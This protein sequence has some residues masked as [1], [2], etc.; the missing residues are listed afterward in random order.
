[1]RNHLSVLID[2]VEQWCSQMQAP[3]HAVN[4]Q[5]NS[6][7][8]GAAVHLLEQLQREISRRSLEMIFDPTSD[9]IAVTPPNSKVKTRSISR[10]KFAEGGGSDTEVKLSTSGNK[11]PE[12]IRRASSQQQISR[13]A[14]PARI[15][16]Q[17]ALAAR[18]ARDADSDESPQDTK[19]KYSARI[20]SVQRSK[21]SESEE[22]AVPDVEKVEKQLRELLG[23][24]VRLRPLERTASNRH[25]EP[26]SILNA[27]DDLD[28]G[29][30][31][32]S[33]RRESVEDAAKFLPQGLGQSTWKKETIGQVL[34]TQLKA[35]QRQQNTT[36]TETK[37]T[38]SSSDPPAASS[39]TLLTPRSLKSAAEE[40]DRARVRKRK[41]S[42]SP[43]G[44]SAQRSGSSGDEPVPSNLPTASAS[45]VT[46][47]LAAKILAR[48]LTGHFG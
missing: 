14:R 22:K 13:G 39:P 24:A 19:P 48:K 31:G 33:D 28:E 30:Q 12:T 25:T 10:E 16:N 7:E 34:R 18:R 42:P 40:A 37:T 36:N 27:I 17:S 4:A 46:S 21:S 38:K 3:V 26:L 5:L 45:Q 2:W 47:S 1:M 32:N 41:S 29:Q 23:P 43:P 8:S 44:F 11:M 15:R 6:L 35:R 9:D 20:L